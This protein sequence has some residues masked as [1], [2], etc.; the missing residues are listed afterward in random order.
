L[1]IQNIGLNSAIFS[2][3]SANTAR[4]QLAIASKLAN[5][6]AQSLREAKLLVDAAEQNMTRS[7]TAALSEFG[8]KLD[9][10]A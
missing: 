1:Q 7:V 10:S 9:I 4:I 5:S 8:N 6:E 3:F 2:M